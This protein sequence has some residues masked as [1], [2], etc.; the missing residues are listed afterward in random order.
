MLNRLRLFPKALL[1]APFLLGKH[2]GAS[3]LRVDRALPRLRLRFGRFA[4]R[5]SHS[6]RSFENAS[7]G[8]LARGFLEN[9]RD[10]SVKEIRMS[11]YISIVRIKLSPT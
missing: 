4:G 11:S 9:N 10:I 8:S 3:T 2:L 1:G 6:L 7:L 5:I